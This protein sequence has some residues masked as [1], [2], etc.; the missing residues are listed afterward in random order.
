MGCAANHTINTCIITLQS[1]QHIKA[2][3]EIFEWLSVVGDPVTEVD[4][5]GHLLA[6]LPESYNVLVTALEVNIDV[7]R[8][9]VVTEHLIREKQKLKEQRSID[10]TS[11]KVMAVKPRPKRKG[12]RCHYC[13][14]F[15][16]IK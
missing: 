9:E 14:R 1:L 11:V 2:M 15:G 10:T 7:P 13:G 4:R 12:P 5:V 16:H 8:M 3:M 6:S